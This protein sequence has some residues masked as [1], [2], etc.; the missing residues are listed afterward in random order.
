MALLPYAIISLLVYQIMSRFL[1]PWIKSHRSEEEVYESE[2]WKGL[3]RCRV[4]YPII[5][6][7]A[8]GH[9]FGL[10]ILYSIA[11]GAASQLFYHLLKQ[12]LKKKGISMPRFS[13]TAWKK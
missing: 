1:N 11:A 5:L 10:V 8:F 3:A 4:F 13:F 12:Y 6:G 7:A 9:L 2:V